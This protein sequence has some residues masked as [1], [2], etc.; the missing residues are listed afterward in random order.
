MMMVLGLDHHV[1][2]G[3]FK[4]KFYACRF[5]VVKLVVNYCCGVSPEISVFETLRVF[6]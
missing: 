1:M 6:S 5:L 3:C 2:F 4:F